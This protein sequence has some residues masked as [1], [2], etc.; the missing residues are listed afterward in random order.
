MSIVLDQLYQWRY[1]IFNS[2]V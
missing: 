1:V 2:L